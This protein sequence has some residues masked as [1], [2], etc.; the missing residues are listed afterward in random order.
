M[1]FL[2]AA[3]AVITG[4]WYPAFVALA[5]LV[6][7]VTPLFLS[8]WIRVEIPPSFIAAAVIFTGSALILGEVFDF[9]DRFWWWD[10][11]MHGVGALGV[12]MLGF[13]LIFMMFQGDKY[14]APPYAVALFAFC[15]AMAVGV[16]WEVFEFTMDSLLG[17]NMQKSGL[18]DTMG[19]LIVDGVGALI[20][21]GSGWFYLKSRELGGLTGVIDE[22]VRRNPHLFKGRRK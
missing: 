19:D 7:T 13:V 15:F 2:F 12:G 10:I 21:A 1:L 6:L 8:R 16:L 9:Y 3:G 20:G 22:F 5:T 17:T 11:G 4:R 18:L 14:A